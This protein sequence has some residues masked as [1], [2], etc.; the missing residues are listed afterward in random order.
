[1]EGGF[2]AGWGLLQ[3]LSCWEKIAGGVNAWVYASQ[4]YGYPGEK[5]LSF[6]VPLQVHAIDQHSENLLLCL[7]PL[8][9]MPSGLQSYDA[10]NA[11]LLDAH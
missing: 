3:V 1:M 7:E 6:Y 4:C 10:E 9:T 11:A 5:L 8:L 2:L